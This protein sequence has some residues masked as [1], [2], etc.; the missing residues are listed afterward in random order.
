[1]SKSACDYLKLKQL[2]NLHIREETEEAV[3]CM[4]MCLPYIWDALKL[5]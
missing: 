3:K 5:S 2:V 1:M 4:S